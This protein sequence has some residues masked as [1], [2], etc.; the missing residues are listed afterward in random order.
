MAEYPMTTCRK[1]GGP[2]QCYM[3]CEHVVSGEGVPF[4]VEGPDDDPGLI[5]CNVCNSLPRPITKVDKLAPICVKCAVEQGWS[6][7]V[8]Q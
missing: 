8:V 7:A 6:T 1:H 5:L 3:V 4:H 2:V